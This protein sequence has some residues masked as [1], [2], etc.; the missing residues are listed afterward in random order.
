MLADDRVLLEGALGGVIG[1][2]SGTHGVAEHM[3]ADPEAPHAE[4]DLDDLP[5]HVDA[6]DERIPDVAQQ[7]VAEQLLGPVDR[8]D[9]HGAVLDHDLACA[10]RRVGG[11]ADLEELD[12][13]DRE[14]RR[15]VCWE[16]CCVR[17][18]DVEGN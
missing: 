17:A 7:R 13:L 3:V 14:P 10:R 8:V 2:G 15:R 12:V 18:L 16:A 9:G 11:R 4:A 6:Q 1:R 5:G